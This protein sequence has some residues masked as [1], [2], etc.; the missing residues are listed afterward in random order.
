[1]DRGDLGDFPVK[2]NDL[3]W[4]FFYKVVLKKIQGTPAFRASKVPQVPPFPY[5]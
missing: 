2:K 1:M 5:A 3:P 4:T